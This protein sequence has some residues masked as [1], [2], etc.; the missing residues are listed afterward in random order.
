[1]AEEDRLSEGVVK[2]VELVGI[3]Q[4]SFSDAA[5]QAV[6]EA[7]KTI[8]GITGIEVT[9]S[10]AKVE[11]GEIT[12]YSVTVRLAFKVESGGSAG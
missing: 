3:S 10:S 9:D 12:Q 4:S 6:A 2:I 5:R 11:G 8:R 1:M 7:S